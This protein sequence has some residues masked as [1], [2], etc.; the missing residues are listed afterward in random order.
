MKRSNNLFVVAFGLIVTTAAALATSGS[1]TYIYDSAGRVRGAVYEDGS[2]QSY[3]YDAAGNRLETA[4]TGLSGV[5]I[6]SAASVTEGGTVSLGVTRIGTTSTAI[7]L[8]VS[9]QN[10]T[11]LAG[12]NYTTPAPTYT[13]AAGA[14][15]GT[16]PVITIRDGKYN[17]KLGFNV[18]IGSSSNA[19]VI[20]RSTAA[21]TVV[22]DDATDLAPTFAIAGPASLSEGGTATYTVTKTHATSLSH[23]VQY[24]TVAGT[25]VSGADYVP[26]SGQLTFA[27]A[28]T[29]KTFTVTTAH[30][31]GFQLARI[32]S[33]TLSA[34]TN[35][36]TLGIGSTTTTIND[37]DPAPVFTIANSA[38]TSVVEGD[39]LTFTVSKAN[40]TN[41]THAITFAAV[42]GTATNGADFTV[43]TATPLVF[44]PLETSKTIS[45]NTIN[46][47]VDEGATNETFS[48]SVSAASNGGAVGSPSSGAGQIRESHR[49][50]PGVPTLTPSYQSVATGELST[51]QWTVP[52]GYTTYYELYKQKDTAPTQ[53]L[54]YSGTAN[55]YTGS[56][57]PAGTYSVR[58]RACNPV[59][60]GAY[61]P[62]VIVERTCTNC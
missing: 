1:T 41:E 7:T 43:A 52:P 56:I 6:V 12:T 45:V 53:T 36:A 11:A 5:S 37:V 47:S 42:N 4:T 31:S 16:I 14:T 17:G 49:E 59:G 50:V 62:D 24:A 38:P 13:L 8:N 15:S 18:T 32:F 34:P 51:N 21:V 28:E 60:C 35:G 2:V 25:A 55:S 20:S 33:G 40:A 58:V 48:I 3:R 29:S 30:T 9:A 26:G 57:G 23:A 39:V 46:D 61:S 27:P 10:G 54:M 19:V 44:S 22:N